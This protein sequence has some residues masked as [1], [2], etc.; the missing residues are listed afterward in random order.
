[1]SHD[2][3]EQRRSRVVVE[4]PT[5][6]RE[7][8]HSQTVRAPER[9]G[10]ST[11]MVAAVALAAIAA[12]AIIFLFIMNRGDNTDSTNV[13][14]RASAQPTPV[15]QQPV[16]VPQPAAT[17]PT[18]IIIQQAPPVTTQPA[19]VIITQPAAPPTTTTAP[20][21]TA[22]APPRSG[23]DDATLQTNIDR[24]FS[25]DPELN[26][27]DVTAVIVEG[28]VTLNGTVKSEALKQRAEKLA[29]RVKGVRSVDN[30]LVV[31]GG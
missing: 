27:A 20:P 12:T 30:K 15:T 4:T 18:P 7:V 23:A 3:E 22:S 21:A 26:T 16:Y 29:Y 8:V 14:I 13:N 5:A 19:P 11:G 17:Q 25:D 1:M 2:E 10:Y 9:E 24:A 28:K 31:T 6:R